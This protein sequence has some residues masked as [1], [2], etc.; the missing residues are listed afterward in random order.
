M[1]SIKYVSLI[2]LLSIFGCAKDFEEMNISP[3]SPGTM[4]PD[5][6]ITYSQLKAVGEYTMNIGMEQRG[7]MQ[8][9][10][11]HAA[12]YGYEEGKE[13]YLPSSKD[14]FWNRRYME[15]LMNVQ[16]TI[17]VCGDDLALNNKKQIARIWRSY[18]F[19]DL[20]DLWGD[21]PFSEA[22]KGTSHGVLTPKYDTQQN[23]YVG[24]VNELL[25]A[26]ASLMN[27]PNME[28]FGAADLIYNGDIDK[29]K[30]FAHSVCLRIAM[31][32]SKVSPQTTS[33]ILNNLKESELI[34][35]NDDNAEFPFGGDQK[36]FLFDHY[37][38]QDG[39]DVYC[40]PSKFLVD[41]MANSNDP[42]LEVFFN[43]AEIPLFGEYRGIPNLLP[44]GH[45]EWENQE[46][47]DATV[48][49]ST[50]G[51]WFLRENTP[52]LLIGYSEVCLLKAEAALNGWWDES[53]QTLYEEGVEASITY[54]DSAGLSP[55]NIE[56]YIQSLPSVDLE[57]IITQKY[58]SFAYMNVLEAYADYRRTGF[59]MLKDYW[60]QPID[61]SKMPKRFTYPSSEYFQNKEN[62]SKAVENIGGSDSEFNKLWWDIN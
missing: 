38:N 23:I 57:N 15:A 17:N 49:C 60:G 11:Y 59:P 12:R 53:A 18:L 9:M 43:P 1:K 62:V 20:V 13:Y 47:E 40:W 61:E 42:R 5:M 41:L 52:K 14:D 26:S 54:Y 39:F 8:W 19:L 10:M 3:N 34:S 56:T 24:I 7:I 33:E 51:N 25:E 6:L 45:S 46:Y 55:N 44:T 27:D 48:F 36:N 4:N 35:S 2:F 28:S 21:I 29:W 16:E 30:K 37:N 32:I 50:L 58:I 31:R 22:L